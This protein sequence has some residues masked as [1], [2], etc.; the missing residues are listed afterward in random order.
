[1]SDLWR[2]ER[3]D[4]S[5]RREWNEFVARSRNATFLF[6]RDYMDYHS[7]RFDDASRMAYKGNRLMALLPANVTGD[8]ILHSHGG[9]TYGGWILPSSHLDGADLLDIFEELCAVCR[10]EGLTGIDYKPL[11]FIYSGMPSQEDEYA[12]FRIG[13]SLTERNLSAAINLRCPGGFNQQ[14]RRHFSKTAKMPIEVSETTDI[15]GFMSMLADCLRDRHDTAP[16]HTDREMKLLAGR[17]PDNIRFFVTR[18]EGVPHVGVCVYD[19]GRVAH[20]QYIATTEEGRRL[21]LLTPLFN[22][23]IN[24]LFADRDYFD[25]GISNE[26]HGR[27]LNE[28]LLRQKYSYGATGVAYS[29]YFI[30]L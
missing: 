17:F 27:Y 24:D 13:A 16:V 7:D 26:D 20:A 3:Y 29:R 23:L 19:T 9:L 30:S 21:N 4:Q 5:R 25:F 2:I 15:N 14:Q 11:P 10:A 22:Y 28:G 6:D 1:M 8:R 12:L 18:F